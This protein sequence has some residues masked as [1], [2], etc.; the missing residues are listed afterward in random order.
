MACVC[1]VVV[2][3]LLMYICDVNI[4]V[5]NILRVYMMCKVMK[6]YE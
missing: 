4:Y 5:C 2:V 1:V 6:I 3:V